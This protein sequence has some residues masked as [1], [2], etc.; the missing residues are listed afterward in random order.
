VKEELLKILCC[1]ECQEDLAL[2]IQ[3]GDKKNI[4]EGT[5]NC[6]NCNAT[7]EIFD[8][9]PYFSSEIKHGGIKNQFETYSHWFMEMHDEQSIIDSN[10]EIAFFNSLTIDENE[11]NDKLILDAGCGNGRFSYVVS[12]YN[13]K[14]LVS[15]DISKGLMKA[16]ETILKHN[17]EANLAFV[18]GDITAPPFKKEVFDITYSWGVTHHTPNTKKTF[19]TM[20]NLVKD[21]GIFGIYVYVFNPSYEYD[22]QILGLLAYL[23]SFLLIRPFR[24][25][26]SRLPV[27]IVKLIFQ[28]IFYI[29]KFLGFGVFGNHGY[30]SDPF[31]KDR[32]FRVVVD[33][34]KKT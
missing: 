7:Y 5:F 10:H 3:K 20:S 23:R 4:E 8:D 12:K 2:D 15:L 32:Y 24:F 29:E 9:I 17:P 21:Q 6:T 34:L 33:R 28:P 27:S 19:I 26:C 14:L 11:F 13:P 16:K 1:P 25:I 22:K 30:P 31:D 18:Q